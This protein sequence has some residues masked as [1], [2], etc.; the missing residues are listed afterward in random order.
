M[1]RTKFRSISYKKQKYNVYYRNYHYGILLLDKYSIHEKKLIF[2]MIFLLHYTNVRVDIWVYQIFS[3]I[4][5]KKKKRKKESKLKF[6]NS[7]GSVIVLAKLKINGK[8][9]FRD[10]CY[11]CSIWKQFWYASTI[12]CNRKKKKIQPGVWLW[13]LIRFSDNEF[14]DTSVYFLLKNLMKFNTVLLFFRFELR[15]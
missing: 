2:H 10:L 1:K 3:R 12:L 14:S 7:M 13:C 9:D 6:V 11:H 5:S 15:Q 4:S 8:I